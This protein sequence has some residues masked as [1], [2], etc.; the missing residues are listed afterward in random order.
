ME[1]HDDMEKIKIKIVPLE[2]E[3]L[4]LLED[5]NIDKLTL[6]RQGGRG[7]LIVITLMGGYFSKNAFQ[8]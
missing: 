4:V 7:K 2:K 3:N 1:T 8:Q 6:R 5:I